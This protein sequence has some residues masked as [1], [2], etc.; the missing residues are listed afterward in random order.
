MKK[1]QK[2]FV[3]KR[4]REHGSISNVYAFQHYILRLGSIIYSL[5]KEGWSIVGHFEIKKGR[6]SRNYVYELV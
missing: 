2:Q 6:V 1:T 3:E 5:R 4:L